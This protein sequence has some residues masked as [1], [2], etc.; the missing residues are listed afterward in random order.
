M[1]QPNEKTPVRK[2]YCN[3][4]DMMKE[5]KKFKKTKIMSNE[6]G[7]MFMDIA[8]KLS[9]HSYFRYYNNNVKDELISCAIHRMVQY[10]H[11]FDARR[12]KSNA[13]AYF[14]QI[15]WNEFV[16]TCKKHYKQ[17]NLKN[18]IANNYLSQLEG[19]DK[20]CDYVY[21]KKQLNEM[22]ESNSMLE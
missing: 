5:L 4:S 16:K 19:N 2:I 18:N 14:T 6:L 9:G 11:R 21:L 20:L 10:A 3:N 22:I 15:A 12:T 1:K 13:F 17:I 8:N 7:Q